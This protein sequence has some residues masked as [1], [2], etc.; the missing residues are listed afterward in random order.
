MAKN[1][2]QTSPQC[3]FCKKLQVHNTILC[4]KQC[5]AVYYCDRECQRKHW[6]DHKATC[7]ALQS[8]NHKDMKDNANLE[9]F[10]THLTPSQ[11]NKLVQIIGRKCIVL[12][13]LHNKEVN[14][15]W[16]T[17]AQV[18]L[19]S[20]RFLTQS[21]PI[22]QIR[23]LSELVETDLKLTAANGSVI[24]YIG[25]VELAFT[26]SSK[27]TQV[28]VPFLVTT[29]TIEHP[30]IGYNVIEE[31]VT[32]E[33]NDLLSEIQSSFVGL[34]NGAAQA[35][36]N[37]VQSADS[38]YLCNVKT[39][40]RDVVIPSGKQVNIQC[41]VNTGPI[42]GTTPVLFEPDETMPWPSC[43]EINETL[44]TVKKGKTNFI[45]VQANNPTNHDIVIKRRTVLGRLQLV[46]SVTAI[47]VKLREETVENGSQV[48]QTCKVSECSVPFTNETQ[49]T[50]GIPDHIKNIDLK[51]LTPEQR[52]VALRMLAQEADA[53]SQ[54][55]DDI[56][57]IPDLKVTIKL[58]DETPVQKNYTAVPRPLY[59][60]FKS[61]V[62]DLLNKNFIRKS[63]SPYSSPV[64][65]VR[66]K[67]QTLRLCI[68]YRE[69]NKKASQIATLYP[70]SKRHLTVLGEI[71]GSQY[72]TKEKHTIK[73][74]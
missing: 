60:E 36:I 57:C 69:L 13:K 9:F 49:P 44:L 27:N 38:D 22:K 40:K 71:H 2:E 5:K 48:D 28:R 8:I 20:E 56:G 25:W 6:H 50:V 42:C 61:Y 14:V 45:E 41:R 73:G 3:A 55:D 51:G 30:I 64:V 65:C 67:D 52:S 31:I 19:V 68:D 33:H 26:L 39:S 37:F 35:L 63:T 21:H 62:E 47:P 16:D 4:C 18:S 1:I 74:L 23:S 72:W 11:Q 53:F 54:N 24:P 70:G 29:E 46:R 34:D 10:A 17:G 43:L 58:N 32:N 15:L 66:K 7:V 59:P 12:G